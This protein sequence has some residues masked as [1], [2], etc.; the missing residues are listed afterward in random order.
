[1]SQSGHRQRQNRAQVASFLL[2]HSGFRRHTQVYCCCSGFATQ[3][4]HC[5]HYPERRGYAE[6]PQS[7]DPISW[8]F[9]HQTMLWQSVDWTGDMWPHS[10]VCWLLCIPSNKFITYYLLVHH[11]LLSRNNACTKH[12]HRES[13]LTRHTT[14]KDTRAIT[15]QLFTTLT[16]Y[17]DDNKKW[18]TLQCLQTLAGG[19]VPHF[20][21]GVGI[22][23]HQNVVPEFHATSQR[24]MTDQCVKTRSSL[25]TPHADWRVQWTTDD[26]DS[27]KLLS[28]VYT[29]MHL[30]LIIDNK[31]SKKSRTT[32]FVSLHFR[33]GFTKF[34]QQLTYFIK[35]DWT[36]RE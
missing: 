22:T 13:Y 18:Q 16:W 15:L 34:Q 7:V 23:G 36:C 35:P 5:L 12:I 24:L 4:L 9:H 28:T 2:C 27:I 6:I 11:Y 26:V 33:T 1:L 14:N 31:L 29:L 30:Y 20:D 17:R 8:P 25:S 3:R 21:G 10:D 32:C 19:D